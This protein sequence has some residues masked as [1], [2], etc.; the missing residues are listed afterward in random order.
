MPRTKTKTRNSGVSTREQITDIL[1]QAKAPLTIHEISV[2]VYG[3]DVP[4]YADQWIRSNVYKLMKEGTVSR[5]VESQAERVF[6]ANGRDPRGYHAMLYWIGN[7]VPA[8]TVVEAIDGYILDDSGNYG[9]PGPR[10]IE[11][12]LRKIEARP[13]IEAQPMTDSKPGLVEAF[14]AL[15]DEI[16]SLKARVA[17]L[18]TINSKL[19]DALKF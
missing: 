1:L 14:K 4:D 17:A 18:E 15:T 7:A 11:S 5:R 16:L 13:G 9:T 12:A 8:R 3:D 2:G 6:R 19:A 10:K